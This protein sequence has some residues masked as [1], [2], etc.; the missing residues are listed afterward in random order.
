MN[1]KPIKYAGEQGKGKANQD[2]RV[3]AVDWA[4]SKDKWE[5]VKKEGGEVKQEREDSDGAS[6]EASGEEDEAEE[7]GVEEDEDVEMKEEDE[8]VKPVKPTLPTV[9]VG[10]TLFIR[11]LPFEVTEQELNTL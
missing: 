11:N 10:S 8:D 5:E 7:S 4:L 2:E 3:V 6:D 9:D 1:G